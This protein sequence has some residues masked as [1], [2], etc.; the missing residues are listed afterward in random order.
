M[1]ITMYWQKRYWNFV[2]SF[3]KKEI[4]RWIRFLLWTLRMLLFKVAL[5]SIR[6]ST[7]YG[8]NATSFPLLRKRDILICD[9]SKICW[10]LR[11][12]AHIHPKLGLMNFC[13]RNLRE[14]INFL[15]LHRIS[16]F[17][18]SHDGLQL[19]ASFGREFNSPRVHSKFTI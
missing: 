17:V 8:R 19:I 4:M 14:E 7:L 11:L 15:S 9:F 18:L 2:R 16:Y 12:N 1:A 3:P 5:S 6:L 13:L 10:A